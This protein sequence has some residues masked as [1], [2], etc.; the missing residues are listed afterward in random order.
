LTLNRRGRFWT[1]VR[2]I[3]LKLFTSSLTVGLRIGEALGLKWS[4]IDFYTGTLRVNR[5]LQWYTG[6]G[7][8]FSEPKH[9]SRRTV[10]LSQ[11]TVEALRRHRKRQVERS[12][13]RRSQASRRPQSVRS[14]TGYSKEVE[15]MAQAPESWIG[16]TVDVAFYQQANRSGKLLEV[17]DDGIVLE[18]VSE[19]DGELTLHTFYPWNTLNYV[20]KE[21]RSAEGITPRRRGT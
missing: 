4:D 9:G 21:V 20:R 14:G 10:D 8:V 2:E 7:L 6:K 1:P 3:G 15:N 19:R 12:R 17:N 11:R 16:E 18:E 5:Q 13:R